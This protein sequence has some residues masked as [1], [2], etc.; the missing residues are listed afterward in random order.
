MA[1]SMQVLDSQNDKHDDTDGSVPTG[2]NTD[3]TSSLCSHVE[4][5]DHGALAVEEHEV[6][7]PAYPSWKTTSYYPS[8]SPAE[9]ALPQQQC[10]AGLS[11]KTHCQH[12]VLE[13]VELKAACHDMAPHSDPLW[14]SLVPVGTV[15]LMP[16]Q[17]STAFPF[18][19]LIPLLQ[20]SAGTPAKQID[21]TS[22]TLKMTVMWRNLPNNYS[23]DSLLLLIDGEGFAGSYDFFYAPYDFTNNALVGYAFTNFV[24]TEEANRFFYHF[25]GFSTWSLNSGKVSEVT[26]S[27][28]LQGLEGHIERYRNSPVMHPDVSDEKKPILFRDGSRIPFPMPTRRINAPQLKQCRPRAH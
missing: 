12:G 19:P 13:M 10:A 16:W 4:E 6:G 2:S 22:M 17:Q 28:P 5:D 23:R 21:Y 27:Q 7:V 11:S 9:E 26:W 15:V 25:Q 14:P 1:I 3:D 24:S 8:W 18:T 20:Q